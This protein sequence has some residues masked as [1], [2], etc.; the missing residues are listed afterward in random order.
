[1]RRQQWSNGSGR[2]KASFKNKPLV[3][4]AALCVRA[5]NRSKLYKGSFCQGSGGVAYKSEA[6]HFWGL[7][8]LDPFL[9]KLHSTSYSLSL[10]HLADLLLLLP[11]KPLLTV[12]HLSHLFLVLPLQPLLS[13]MHLPS[14]LL[15]LPLL[16]VLLHLCRHDARP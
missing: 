13:F 9:L 4:A 12:R 8:S 3:H 7:I 14:L 11:L 1:M 2:M 15:L 6:L 5:A 16:L 10:V